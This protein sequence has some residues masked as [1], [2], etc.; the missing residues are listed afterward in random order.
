M[1]SYMTADGVTLRANGG[2]RR[3]GG[4]FGGFG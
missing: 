1:M 2:M 3:S 4:A